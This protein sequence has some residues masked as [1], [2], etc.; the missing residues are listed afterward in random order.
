MNRAARKLIA[1]MLLD[2]RKLMAALESGGMTVAAWQKKFSQYLAQYHAAEYVVGQRDR[3]VGAADKRY[4]G[5][6]VEAQLGFLDK[7]ATEIQNAAAYQK[8]WN[9]RAA[10][11]AQGIGQSY[12]KGKTK[13]LPLPAMP[14]DGTSQCLTNCTCSWEIIELEGDG[15]Y[16]C[17]WRLGASERHCQTCPTRAR[18]WAPLRIR[19]GRLQ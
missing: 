19:D 11:Y 7:F 15:N 4:L 9:S 13:M 2:V 17:Y 18:D 1:M 6:T 3:H 16:D 5:Q 10:M 8:G 14:R 12:W